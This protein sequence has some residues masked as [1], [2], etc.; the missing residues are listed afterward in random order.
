MRKSILTLAISAALAITACAPSGQTGLTTQTDTMQTT[1]NALINSSTLAYQAPPFNQFKMQDYEPAFA[2]GM[3]QHA[4]EIAAIANNPAPPTFDNT[5][6]A[7]EKSGV[8]LNRVAGIF[9]GLSGV[10]SNDEFQRIEADMA[11]KLS[12]HNDNIYL[13]PTLFKRVEAIYT[14][15]DN[16]S[17]EDQR[18]VDY[19]YATFVRAGAKLDD[20]QKA[21]M[22]GINEKISS[23][24]T[25]FSQNLM[26]SFKNDVIVVQ[27]KTLLAGLSDADIAALAEAAS[28]AGKNG[29]MITLVNTTRQPILSSLQNRELRE[30]IWRQ[31]AHRAMDSNG[32]VLLSLVKLRAEKASLLGFPNWA[33]YATDDQMAKTPD[34]VFDILDALAPKAVAKAQAEALDIEQQMQADGLSGPVQP[35]DWASMQKKSE[36]LNMIWMTVWLNPILNLI[37]CCKTAYFL[38]WRSSMASIL[39]RDPIYRFIIRT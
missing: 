2:A 22:R 34:A 19:Y 20:Q 31:S 5:L 35:W 29:Y 12:A 13:N 9:F 4:S 30:Q 17:P 16:L 36:R 18:L 26:A 15:K 11:P 7:M 28:G 25:E 24:Q 38:R 27:D 23:L 1:Q 3:A 39:K 32:P 21:Q 37:Q 14:Q 33:S 8:L 6:V 10:I